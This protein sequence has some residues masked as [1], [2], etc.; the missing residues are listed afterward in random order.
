[1]DA[2][3][4]ID[5][6]LDTL[7]H[8]LSF[9]K[10]KKIFI[11]GDFNFDL[12]KIS[13]HTETSMFFNKMTSNFLLPTIILPTKINT[14]NDTLIDNIFTNQLNPDIISGNLAVSISDH[15]PSFLIIPRSNQNPKKHNI[16]T[17]DTN[18]YDREKFLLDL[19]SIDWEETIDD[20]DADK[21]FNNFIFQIN[22][23]SDKYIPLKR[24]LIKNT[25]EDLNYGLQKVFLKVLKEKMTCLKN[26]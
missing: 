11:A 5:E 13:T 18:N 2:K 20:N 24:S 12:L 17:R 16:F 9:E 6:K 1:M 8:K 21:S 26:L 10:H 15:I 25:E 14:S 3:N 7:V 19:L 23:I 4:F 22:Y